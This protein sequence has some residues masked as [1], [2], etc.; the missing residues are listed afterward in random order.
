MEECQVGGQGLLNG[1][2]INGKKGIATATRKE[3]GEID[4]RLDK[5]YSNG[6]ETGIRSFPFF[7]GFFI[8]KNTISS[9][10]DGFDLSDEIIKEIFSHNQVKKIKELLK[11]TK[12]NLGKILVVLMAGSLAG[13][14]FIILPSILVYLF[15]FIFNANSYD[16]SM[17]ESAISIIILVIYLFLLGKNEEINNM[18]K[19]HGAEHKSIFCYEDGKE[20]NIQNVKKQKRLHIRCGTN[21]L[22]VAFIL[23]SVSYLFMPWD[24]LFVRIILKIL[25]IPFIASFSYEVITYAAKSNNLLARII[26]LPG[27]SLQLLTT[28]EP[29]EAQIEVAILAL[30][31]AEGLEMEKTIRELLNEA[32]Q[33]FKKAGIESYILDAQLLMCHVLKQNKLYLMTNVYDV[34]QKEKAEEFI[35]LVKK[36]ETKYPMKYILKTTEFMGIDFVIEEG[37][38]IPRPDTEVLVQAVLDNIEKY[39]ELDVCDLCCGSGAIGLTI[40]EYRSNT[41][42]D[43]LDI[44]EAPQRVTNKNIQG[45]EISD[46]ATFIHSDLFESVKNKKYDIIVSNPPYIKEEVIETLMDDVKNFEPHLALSGGDDGLIFYRKITEDSVKLLKGKAILAFEIGHD[47]GQEVKEMM[48]KNGFGNIQIIKDLAGFDRVVIG[49]LN[50]E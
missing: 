12:N 36:R 24:N 46:R 9:G 1:V 43:L 41:K 38:L 14:I 48:D 22:F 18:F 47:Q 20:L 37:V 25:V 11:I 17:L 13:F 3:N 26:V 8:L 42:V 21:L 40:A 32:N 27:L 2:M 4:L 45:F 6:K 7:R 33:T 28:K 34:V 16:L 30:K 10:V 39:E 29:D 15:N 35:A 19:Y 23:C 44:D 31:K 5:R 49:N 50:V